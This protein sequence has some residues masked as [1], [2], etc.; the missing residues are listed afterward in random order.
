MKIF[1]IFFFIVFLYLHPYKDSYGKTHDF[2]IGI[3]ASYTVEPSGNTKVKNTIRIKNNKEYIYA[4]S[5]SITLTT[6]DLKNI[7]VNDPNG[8]IPYWVREEVEGKK[9]IEAR[10]NNRV[11]GKDV[12]NEFNI[13][14]ETQDLA[15][16]LGNIWEVN[17]PGIFDQEDFNDYSVK[18]VVPESFGE[19]AIL[20][21]KKNIDKKS[22][23]IFFNK[24]EL[25]ESGIFIVFGSQQ[26]FK[27]DLSYHIENPNLFPIKTEVALPSQTSY[28]DVA[29]Q[30]INPAPQNVYQDQDGNWLAEYVLSPR[31]KLNI[32]ALVI[33]KLSSTP[34]KEVVQD[35]I[36]KKY[37]AAAH[38]WEADD[39]M[40]K[41]LAGELKTPK[42][43]YDFVV[44]TLSYNYEKV[45]SQNERLGAKK[46]ISTPKN[47][48]C[49]EFTDLFVALARSAGIQARSVEGYAFTENSRLR[50]LSLVRDVLHSWPQYYDPE[51][52]TW[53]MVDPTWG[54]TTGGMDYFTSFDLSHIAFV[55]KG[56]NSR[57]PIPAGGYK[58]D[59]DSKDVHVSFANPSEFNPNTQ[60]T[61]ESNLPTFAF[62]GLPIKG[63]IIIKN[64]GNSPFKNGSV[65]VESGLSSLKS[66]FIDSIP[67]YGTKVLQVS[68]PKTPIL[69]NR[70]YEVKISSWGNTW[71][72]NIYI[73]LFPKV[74]WVI[75]GGGLGVSAA[76]IIFLTIKTWGLPF[77]R[78][79]K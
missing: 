33:V 60:I 11:I 79:K 54:N 56:A 59:L 58:Q 8:Q 53:V 32:K 35:D 15:K 13:S 10:F 70:S 77:S 67:P 23:F 61:L 29:I 41:K 44:S 65:L 30:K 4:P 5:Y 38:Y 17:I 43:I 47:A 21:P 9:T 34:K 55:V 69:T 18:L 26:F 52:K 14:F 48:V 66:Y 28:Q 73:S 78:S 45:D 25:G 20:K 7:E 1:F 62:S 16:K 63:E 12:V 74:G 39:P 40:I 49:L 76:I 64:E 36:G 51:K 57:Y 42:N 50:P 46:T 72:G 75:V 19:P 68:F 37:F 3:Q 6:K 22:H 71:K 2:D 27:L 31:Q 24:D